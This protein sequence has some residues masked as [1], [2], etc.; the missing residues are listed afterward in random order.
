MTSACGPRI[1]SYNVCY[2]KLL[3][4]NFLLLTLLTAFPALSTDMYL[5]AL[6]HLQQSWGITLMEA[7]S[8]LAAFFACFSFFLLVHGPLSDP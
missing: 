8:S 7:N 6:P 1:T 5:P 4:P 3:R 2:T